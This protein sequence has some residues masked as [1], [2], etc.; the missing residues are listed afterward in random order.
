MTGS[1]PVLDIH[2]SSDVAEP[3]ILEALAS[4][5]QQRLPDAQYSVIFLLM[6]VLSRKPSRRVDPAP[7]CSVLSAKALLD[8][9]P[10]EVVLAAR[11]ARRVL[12]PQ[13]VGAKRLNDPLGLDTVLVR[14]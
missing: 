5:V 2:V 14:V 11:Y 12:V 4:E 9:P 3:E 6:S 13:L 10:D 1:C 7:M 8:P